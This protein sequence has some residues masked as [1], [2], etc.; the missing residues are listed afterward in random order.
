MLRSLLFAILILPGTGLIIIPAIILWLSQNTRYAA[1]MAGPNQSAFWISLAAAAAGL[2]ISVWT[3]LLFLKAGR[4][5]PAPWNP[6]NRL[7]VQ[8][9]YRYV[10][11]P[12]ITSVLLIMISESLFFR[13]WPLAG[14]TIVF[15]AGNVI[16]FPF[17]VS[18]P[19]RPN[20]IDRKK[21][22]D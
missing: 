5:T 13:S 19:A 3:V 12:M 4:G 17:R 22:G 1:Q 2:C 6:P 10:R 11:N 18:L 16:Y 7:V 21:K 20:R 15:F 8:G 9:P 14:W